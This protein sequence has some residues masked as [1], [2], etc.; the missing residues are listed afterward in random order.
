M[1]N[2]KLGIIQSRGLGDILIALPIANYYKKQGW[3]IHWPIC[4]SFVKNFESHV[5]WVNWISVPVDKQGKFFYD[6]P[7]QLLESEQCDEIICLYQSLTGHPE[8]IKRPEFQITKFDQIK[9][10]IAEVP[11]LEKWKLAD[12]ISRDLEK[13]KV[14]FDKLVNKEQKPYVVIHRKGSDFSAK[15][16]SAWIP[17]DYQQIE[18][19]EQS[20]SI[21]DWLTI[22]EKAE[23]L[24][25][26]DSVF[27][28]LVDQFQI[29][30]TVESYFLP[31]SHIHLTPVLGGKWTV[32]EPDADTLKKITIFRMG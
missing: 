29:N 14:L 15:I 3:E 24:L 25:L 18:I 19:E 4:A 8:F 22:L 11:F 26:V 31:R 13:E 32:I 30:N 27:S 9:Y 5:P 20:D 21:F 10:H 7:Y 28:N 17:E 23:C 6:K 12:C 2:K 1:T 16:D